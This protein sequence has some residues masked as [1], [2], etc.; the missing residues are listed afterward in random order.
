MYLRNIRPTIWGTCT[1]VRLLKNGKISLDRGALKLI[2][3]LKGFM[4]EGGLR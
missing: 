1:S 3:S 2:R 4:G